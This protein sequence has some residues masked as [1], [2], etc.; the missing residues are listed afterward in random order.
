M[1]RKKMSLAVI[2]VAIAS[3]AVAAV[4]ANSWTLY[5]PLYTMRM[6]Q[7]SNKM[8]FL[9]TEMNTFTYNTEK[10]YNLNYGT[11]RNSEDKPFYTFQTPWTC[12]FS[13]CVYTCTTCDGPTCPVTCSYTCPDTFFC[14]CNP[15]YCPEK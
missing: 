4:T 8:N 2:G 11:L 1:N 12:V 5:T 15:I 6:E 3:L 13:T 10:G 7:A 9:P 14:T